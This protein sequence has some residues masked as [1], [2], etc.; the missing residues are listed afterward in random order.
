MSILTEPLPDKIRVGGK[1][2]EIACDYR[3]CLRLL[4]ILDRGDEGGALTALRLFYC[5]TPP[6][7]AVE[8]LNQMSGFLRCGEDEKPPD[9]K[10]RPRPLDYTI[11][12]PLILAAFWSE[13]S[14]DLSSNM[15]HWW[16]FRALLEGL[17]ENQRISQIMGYRTVN[18]AEIKD[19]HSKK[20][21]RK[22]QKQYRLPDVKD[23]KPVDIL[24][25][26]SG[27]FG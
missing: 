3:S 15:I 17:G 22:L 6:N 7:N 20:H 13:Y 19:K 25:K 12:A 18:L 14:I 11:D 16:V 8:A 24:A 23:G 27:A 9:G 4:E 2:Y 10:K 21:Y 5:G 1:R 26:A